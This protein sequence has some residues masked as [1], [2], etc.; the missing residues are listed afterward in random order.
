MFHVYAETGSGRAKV[1]FLNYIERSGG[2]TMG[3]NDGA[4][5]GALSVVGPIGVVAG[6]VADVAVGSVGGSLRGAYVEV[7]YSNYG[8][9]APGAGGIRFFAGDFFRRPAWEGSEKLYPK[10]WVILLSDKDGKILIPCETP[11]KPVAK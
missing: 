2:V 8:R 5:A 1:V 3:R 7:D 9:S 10:S 11:C 4:I 6:T